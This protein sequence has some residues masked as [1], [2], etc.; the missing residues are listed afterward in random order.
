[1]TL[2][3]GRFGTSLRLAKR[4]ESLFNP[5]HKNLDLSTDLP[6]DKLAVEKLKADVSS[7][8]LRQRALMKGNFSTVAN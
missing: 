4:S 7:N 5:I 3:V 2:F 8:S 6:D 1:M